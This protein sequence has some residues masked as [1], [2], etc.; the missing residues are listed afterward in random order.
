MAVVTICNE[1]KTLTNIDE[2][3][4]C[5][6]ASGIDYERWNPSTPIAK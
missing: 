4:E 2:I 6:A 3:T 5:L 1:N